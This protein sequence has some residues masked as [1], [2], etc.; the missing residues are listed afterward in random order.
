MDKW[1]F[2]GRSS[3]ERYFLQTFSVGIQ[4]FVDTL[5]YFVKK[6][7]ENYRGNIMSF[8]LKWTCVELLLE[9]SPKKC[10][11]VTKVQ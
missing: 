11:E 7:K 10:C 1:N 2:Q 8:L 6:K 9:N 5:I 3:S 4:N